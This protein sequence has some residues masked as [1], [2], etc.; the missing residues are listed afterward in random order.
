MNLFCP[1]IF[2]ITVHFVEND[3]D[4][5]YLIMQILWT[6]LLENSPDT[7]YLTSARFFFLEGN[8]FQSQCSL[9]VPSE[10]SITIPLPQWL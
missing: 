3:K 5:G 1:L 6:W 4:Y 2:L 9:T 8:N 7:L 10:F